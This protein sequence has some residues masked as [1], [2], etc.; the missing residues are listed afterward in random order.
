MGIWLS[1]HPPLNC[2]S[3]RCWQSELCLWNQQ[4][5][6]TDAVKW[7]LT[8]VI[9]LQTSV[10][11]RLNRLKYQYVSYP[12]NVH[13][14]SPRNCRVGF[15]NKNEVWKPQV[16]NGKSVRSLEMWRKCKGKKKLYP[17]WSFWWMQTCWWQ[18][19]RTKFYSVHWLNYTISVVRPP[20][21]LL[22]PLLLDLK[23]PHC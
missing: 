20:S 10:V 21:G 17:M 14:V 2:S 3:H 22:R 13:H 5:V 4:R 12:N 18:K 23:G 1:K 7:K 16:S 6:A 11:T 19:K 8:E 9:R 15:V